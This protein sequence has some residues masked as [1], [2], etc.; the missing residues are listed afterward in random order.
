MF[1]RMIEQCQLCGKG[2][3]ISKTRRDQCRLFT[4]ILGRGWGVVMSMEERVDEKSFSDESDSDEAMFITPDT[5]FSEDWNYGMKSTFIDYIFCVCFRKVDMDER[6]FLLPNYDNE[7]SKTTF[8][9]RYIFTG[10]R[11]CSE[12]NI[13]EPRLRIL[14]TQSGI[15][16]SQ[17]EVFFLSYEL[18]SQQSL[19]L[20][21]ITVQCGQY[22]EHQLRP[23]P[24]PHVAEAW[25]QVG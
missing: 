20:I 17:L 7:A 19:P 10:S 11:S 16:V 23:H 4:A 1:V 2:V 8:C 3:H 14:S 22:S 6:S 24:C 12:S 25:L 13:P 5:S 18:R 21:L 9:T 15:L